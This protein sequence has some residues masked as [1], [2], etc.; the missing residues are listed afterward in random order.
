[1]TTNDGDTLSRVLTWVVIGVVALF[2]VRLAFT[3]F[4]IAAFVLF[5]L[6]PILLVGWLIVATVRYLSRKPS[7]DNA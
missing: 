2:A 7:G 6:G 4:G 3:L 1:M 5:R